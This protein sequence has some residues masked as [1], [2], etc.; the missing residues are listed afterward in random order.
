MANHAISDLAG[1]KND[2]SGTGSICLGQ[3]S[4]VWRSRIDEHFR[5]AAVTAENGGQ[6]T[7][8]RLRRL[9]TDRLLEVRINTSPLRKEHADVH[10]FRKDMAHHQLGVEIVGK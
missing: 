8:H 6:L 7:I 10:H 4:R 5:L 2:Y 1:T 9:G 3:Q